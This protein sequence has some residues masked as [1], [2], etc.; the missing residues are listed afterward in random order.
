MSGYDIIAMAAALLCALA[1][2]PGTL[3]ILMLTNKIAADA[4]GARLIYQHSI[5]VLIL[6][7]ILIL[8]AIYQS[9]SNGS[10]SLALWGSVVVYTGVCIFGFLMHARF[11]FKPVR[12][13]IF[14]SVESAL[15]KFGPDE[16]VVGVFDSTGKPY[17]FVTRLA[18]RPHIVYQPDGD[19][20]FIMTHCIL[21]HSS[22]AY[23]M[24]GKFKQPDIIITAAMANNMVFYERSNQ[25]AM[26]QL[27]NQLLGADFDLKLLP[28]IGVNLKIWKALYPDSQVWIRD[29]DWRDTFYLKLFA[30][31]DA[32]DPDS[33]VLVYPLQNKLDDREAMKSFVLGVELDNQYKAYPVSIFENDHLVH[34]EIGTTS[35]LLVAAYDNDYIQIFNRNVEGPTLAFVSGKTNDYF[36]D[37]ETRSQWNMQGLCTAGDYEG[38]QLERITH[39]NKIFWFVW[40][41]YH[42]QTTIFGR[43][44]ESA[45]SAAAA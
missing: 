39:Y 13:P 4:A 24:E 43:E 30:R 26:T 36:L 2:L 17:A 21:S 8:I 10:M 3:G 37:N 28:T 16:E 11:L 31:A 1:V 34:D 45:A 29:K 20:P 12:K 5:K 6:S 18:R 44:S 32:I 25:C 14:I 40:A 42:P 23:E 19:T 9:T 27:H 41:D 38:T 33:P 35:L 7:A 15:K 22:M